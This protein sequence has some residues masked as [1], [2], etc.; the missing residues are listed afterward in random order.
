MMKHLR[1]IHKENEHIWNDSSFI[2]SLKSYTKAPSDGYVQ[3]ESSNTN[4][5][6][7]DERN[8]IHSKNTSSDIGSI[9]HGKLYC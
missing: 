9:D 4:E 6:S 3:S 5:S 1:L 8:H 7:T 2:A